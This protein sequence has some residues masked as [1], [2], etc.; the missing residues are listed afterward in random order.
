MTICAARSKQTGARCRQPV[1]PGRRVCHYHG[2]RTPRGP[3]S[4]NFVTGEHSID[5]TLT[6]RGKKR[7]TDPAIHSAAIDVGRLSVLLEDRTDRVRGRRS[8]AREEA[9]IVQLTDARLRALDR[10]RREIEFELDHVSRAQYSWALSRFVEAF[11]RHTS[12]DVLR[13]VQAD[14]RAAF[15]SHPHF[16]AVVE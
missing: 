8:S 10:L 11:R 6:E 16:A 13:L 7:S 9:V 1:V 3:A 5:E 12:A 14:L 4:A 2:G 15:R